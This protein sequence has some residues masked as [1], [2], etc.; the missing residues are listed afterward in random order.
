MILRDFRRISSERLS[1]KLFSTANHRFHRFFIGLPARTSLYRSCNKVRK[2][3][4]QVNKFCNFEK[5]DNQPSDTLSTVIYMVLI[6]AVSEATGA[7][8]AVVATHART[9]R[10]ELTHISEY[11]SFS[12]RSGSDTAIYLYPSNTSLEINIVFHNN[13]HV[14]GPHTH[15]RP[16]LF[17]Y[18]EGFQS[19]HH[20]WYICTLKIS[21]P[22]WHHVVVIDE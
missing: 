13:N 17:F 15:K 6:S 8:S 7:T 12:L 10:A 9:A 11:F 1:N 19:M 3:D 21:C 18:P 20:V 14:S 5:G 16:L 4:I 22:Q 2:D